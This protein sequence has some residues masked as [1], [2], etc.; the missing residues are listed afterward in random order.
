MIV[1][2]TIV[3]EQVVYGKRVQ[4][5]GGPIVALDG[6]HHTGQSAGVPPELLKLCTPK[7]VGIEYRGGN[8]RD[9]P[10]RE[11]QLGAAVHLRECA[12]EW[13]IIA[14][15]AC[16]LSEAGTGAPVTAAARYYDHAQYLLTKAINWRAEALASM[17]DVLRIA[18]MAEDCADLPPLEISAVPSPLPLPEG[19]FERIAPF[20]QALVSGESVAVEARVLPP[21]F[22]E[23]VR[24]CLASLPDAMSCR[25]PIGMALGVAGS[26]FAIAHGLGARSNI[27]LVEKS[28]GLEWRGLGERGT[29]GGCRYVDWLRNR[30]G[31][32]ASVGEL[33]EIVQA[34]WRAYANN[35][36]FPD[37]MSWQ[38]IAKRI[39]DHLHEALWADGLL[40]D[41]D[42]GAEIPPMPDIAERKSDILESLV[43]KWA[44][45]ASQELLVSTLTWTE[46][47]KSMLTREDL[48]P[49]VKALGA[50]TG[51]APLL[52]EHVFLLGTRKLATPL[53]EVLAPALPRAIGKAVDAGP[54]LQLIERGAFN[55]WLATTARESRWLWVDLVCR[56]SANL[57]RIPERL[58]A[59][60]DF[61]PMSELQATDR[62][63]NCEAAQLLVRAIERLG[64]KAARVAQELAGM[65]YQH[66]AALG[67]IFLIEAFQKLLPNVE[68]LLGG[69][70][71]DL[72]ADIERR[73]NAGQEI[74]LQN[75]PLIA[76]LIL[77]Q[78]DENR[79]SPLVRAALAPALGRSA[80]LVVGTPGAPS[81]QETGLAI[82]GA[83]VRR[84]PVEKHS[85]WARILTELLPRFPH[86]PERITEI[87]DDWIDQAKGHSLPLA[88]ILHWHAYHTGRATRPASLAPLGEDDRARSLLTALVRNSHLVTADEQPDSSASEGELF[89]AASR[90]WRKQTLYQWSHPYFRTILAALSLWPSG[91]RHR[92]WLNLI[93]SANLIRLPGWRILWRLLRRQH[94]A[95]DQ[96]F[97]EAD[98]LEEEI[99]LVHRL[100][101]DA[102]IHL[103]LTSYRV[104]DR[105]F[106]DV[107]F[108]GFSPLPLDEDSM[109]PR[110]MRARRRSSDIVNDI[111]TIQL[112]LADLFALAEKARE[113][114]CDQFLRALGTLA[115]RLQSGC[116]NSKTSLL[117]WSRP[118]HT[119]RKLEQMCQRSA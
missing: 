42:S 18:P 31:G 91:E 74:S 20:L 46:E 67:V 22:L 64:S 118:R 92:A 96:A 113:Y 60:H 81:S 85:F 70:P 86:A 21:D 94:C 14:V 66:G 47:W 19:W 29:E 58:F 50:F 69:L 79:W 25:M 116:T 72:A 15:R 109:Q 119:F 99:E 48:P 53:S 44:M 3:F 38:E 33:H 10:W 114:G 37:A 117:P 73:T 2:Q 80:E 7:S 5:S 98:C 52:P 55:E 78:V 100:P 39:A 11:Q 68:L 62:P 65:L 49:E 93:E 103:I 104:P 30:T 12:G 32:A 51:H 71:S 82:I 9:Y 102:I 97:P 35:A 90:A 84:M 36:A 28:G 16:G 88:P 77:N 107:F 40:R 1:V 54:W 76:E 89:F 108:F 106:D 115:G 112:T 83:C 95:S 43:A 75:H 111:R 13:W 57:E 63:P 105:D 4:F 101:A 27:K 61:G 8:W 56:D 24:I 23:V 59:L 110:S 6:Y 17:L 41:L 26:E 34:G 45:P 87:I